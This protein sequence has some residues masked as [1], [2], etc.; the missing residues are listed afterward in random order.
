[1]NACGGNAV[2]GGNTYEWS[3]AEMTL[4]STFD[5]GNIRVTQGVLQPAQQTSGIQENGTLPAGALSVYPVPATDLLYL[6]PDFG[7]AG[8][9]YWEL[10]DVQGRQIA[11]RSAQLA[12]GN[13]TQSLDM[14]T[15]PAANYF[16]RIRFESAQGTVT[17]SYKV[18]KVL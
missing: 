2:S 14:A 13:E 15:L 3:V 10:I 1:M 9:L 12:Q 6:K 18:Q 5:G 11:S 8:K 16:L 4:V 7:K 17:A